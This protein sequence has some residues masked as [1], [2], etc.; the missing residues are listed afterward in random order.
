MSTK[1][2]S[3]PAAMASPEA[4]NERPGASPG[5][6]WHTLPASLGRR[7][8]WT[9]GSQQVHRLSGLLALLS[10]VLPAAGLAANIELVSRTTTVAPVSPI[11]P[12]AAIRDSSTDGRYAVF[13]TEASNLIDDAWGL[14]SLVA[15]DVVLVDRQTGTLERI[16]VD[17][18]ETPRR[19]SSVNFG[20]RFLGISGDGNRVAFVACATSL[21]LSQSGQKCG[22]YLRD[23]AAGTTRL[24]HDDGSPNLSTPIA[25]SRDGNWLAI[26]R[27]G[28]GLHV[29]DRIDLLTGTVSPAAFQAGAPTQ[30]FQAAIAV[31]I[32]ADGSRVAFVTASPLAADDLEGDDDIYVSDIAGATTTLVSR[33]TD[34]SNFSGDVFV[35]FDESNSLNFALDGNGSNRWMSSDGNRF[36]FNTATSLVAGDTPRN[37]FN[38]FEFDGYLRDVGA[39]T[40]QLVYAAGNGDRRAGATYAL[41]ISD[42]GTR[43]A[44]A[45]DDNG[46]FVG[47]PTG[48]RLLLRNMADSNAVDLIRQNGNAVSGHVSSGLHLSGD[49]STAFLTTGLALSTADLTASFTDHY[50]ISTANAAASLLTRPS[51][52]AGNLRSAA[53]DRSFTVQASRDGRVVAFLSTASNL[54][55]NDSNGRQDLFLLDRTGG[56]AATPTRVINDDTCNVQTFDMTPDGRYIAFTGACPRPPENLSSIQAYRLDRRSGEIVLV[57]RADGVNGAAPNAAVSGF[58]ARIADDGQRIAFVSLASNL[59]AG[60]TNNRADAFVRDLAS[61]STRRVSLSLGG[62]PLTSGATG[63]VRISGDGRVVA[64][65]TSQ[66]QEAGDTNNRPDAWLAFVDT[67]TVEL[68]AGS[69][70]ANGS[71]VSGLSADAR[72][73]LFVENSLVGTCSGSCSPRAVRLR[74]RGTGGVQRVDLGPNAELPTANGAYSDLRP[75]LSD[76]GRY[77]AF[78]GNF[79][80]PTCSSTPNQFYIR[81][82]ASNQ[83][84]VV[85]QTNAGSFANFNSFEPVLSAD[86]RFVAFWSFATTLLGAGNDRNGLIADA[87]LAENPLWYELKADS[88]IPY[89]A[90]TAPSRDPAVSADG[91]FVVFTSDDS[92][93]AAGDSNAASDVFLVDRSNAQVVRV[94]VDDAEGQLS[95]PA[96]EPTIS[97]DGSLVAFV[98][99]DAAVMK[100]HGETKQ[101]SEKRRKGGTFGVFLRNIQTGTTR[102]VGTGTTGGSGTEPR[103]APGG[104]GIVY[105][106]TKPDED[107]TK[108]GNGFSHVYRK[109]LLPDGNLGPVACIT[110]KVFDAN[111]NV[112]GADVDGSSRSPVLSADGLSIAFETEAKNMLAGS[113]PCPAASTVVV[114]RNIQTGSTRIASN[115]LAGSQCLAGGARKPEIDH[116]GRRVVFESDL[117]LRETHVDA[118][119]E[120]YLFDADAQRTDH[121]SL[122]SGGSR[123]DGASFQPVISG[124][125]NVVVFTSAATNFNAAQ[126]DDNGAVRDLI[127]YDLRQ[128]AARRAARRLDGTDPNGDSFNPSLDYSGG[129]LAFDSV[130]SNIVATD[131]NQTVSDVFLRGVTLEA[132]AVFRSGFE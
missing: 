38:T 4:E 94:S 60:D 46:G 131:S 11:G 121:L 129:V 21:D 100:V 47:A 2:P 44:V 117:P 87:F 53:D 62:T 118:R 57:S 122:H 91:R 58:D 32:S 71:A 116:S 105:T 101:A 132:D 10:L 42:D 24:I 74:D 73:V 84:A 33:R 17:T 50:A 114:L 127:A 67:G 109:P 96:F 63:T 69:Y 48:S 99:E 22:V 12:S 34:G 9:A 112:T 64:F 68:A 66:V 23:R 124:D 28:G 54:V 76:D 106:S 36:I 115:P 75:Q 37:N 88:I 104:G 80:A 29:V 35:N 30:L 15:G 20:A 6:A 128:R 102:R 56:S 39:N 1:N 113:S 126:L 65:S 61:N 43:V 51:T 107:P 90:T 97:A 27:S 5:S 119:S 40:L 108:P 82:L 25:I 55:A 95:G 19:L 103:L 89:P 110:C 125:G 70:P 31:N 18:N 14:E 98:A 45:A 41:G 3:C 123:V 93:L 72:K 120:V 59:V 86:G 49:A 77:V 83:L 79:C 85:T 52:A 16:N 7:A 111:G 92:S 13:V 78:L 8:A 26:G 81:E 130:A